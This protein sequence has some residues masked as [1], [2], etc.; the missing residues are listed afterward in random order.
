MRTTTFIIP[1]HSFPA[2]AHR[3]NNPDCPDILKQDILVDAFHVTITSFEAAFC[4]VVVI[5]MEETIVTV[6]T[7]TG[8]Y[9]SMSC[10]QQK[11]DS[12]IVQVFN[13][14]YIKNVDLENSSYKAELLD[15]LL[16][17]LEGSRNQEVRAIYTKHINQIVFG[18]V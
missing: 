1:A 18:E 2:P 5:A 10:Y 13:R 11:S 17:S 3:V 16:D 8:H 6:N 7:S 4:Y 14:P 12:E 15:L 9:L